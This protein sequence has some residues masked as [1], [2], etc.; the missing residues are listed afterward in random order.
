MT[1]E[2]KFNWAVTGCHAAVYHNNGFY[3]ASHGGTGIIWKYDIGANTKTRVAGAG[4]GAGAAASSPSSLL[5]HAISSSDNTSPT[6]A[7]NSSLRLII[8]GI[9][10][11]SSIL[12][13]HKQ[14]TYEAL[15]EGS[16]LSHRLRKGQRIWEDIAKN[17]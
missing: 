3:V 5:L 14:S 2:E 12:P 17:L 16:T 6:T 11:S 10:Y 7:D 8:D 4:A 13:I 9:N 15:I 1:K